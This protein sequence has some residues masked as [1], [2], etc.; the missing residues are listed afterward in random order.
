[1]MMVMGQSANQQ[2]QAG[3]LGKQP[4]QQSPLR[5][6]RYVILQLTKT[7]FLTQVFDPFSGLTWT[8]QIC[9]YQVSLKTSKQSLCR[10]SKFCFC[11]SSSE[12][13]IYFFFNCDIRIWEGDTFQYNTNLRCC[14][15]CLRFKLFFCTIAFIFLPRSSHNQNLFLPLLCLSSYYSHVLRIKCTNS[16]DSWRVISFLQA[17]AVNYRWSDD[18]VFADFAAG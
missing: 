16:V 7:S 14:I 4:Q 8:C 5:N 11:C 10:K 1:M 2:Q 9:D 12:M 6:V 17:F 18:N 13:Y 3:H 15:Q